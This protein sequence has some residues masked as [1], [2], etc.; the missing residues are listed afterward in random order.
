MGMVHYGVHAQ[1]EEAANDLIKQ[2]L[3]GSTSQAAKK[4]ILTPWKERDRRGREVYTSSGVP[5]PAIRKGMYRRVYNRAYPHLNSRD[6]HFRGMR[7]INDHA[8]MDPSGFADTARTSAL[9]ESWAGARLGFD[10]VG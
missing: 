8:A 4:D 6:G 7:V 5:D 9:M 10:E 3:D 1:L 2:S